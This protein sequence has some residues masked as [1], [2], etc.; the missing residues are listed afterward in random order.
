MARAATAVEQRLDVA[1]IFVAEHIE[2]DRLGGQTGF[3]LTMVE[4]QLKSLGFDDEEIQ[5]GGLRITSTFDHAMQKAATAAVK[6]QGPT[7][8]TDGLRIGLLDNTKSPV[9]KML[10]RLEECLAGRIPGVQTRHFAKREMGIPAPEAL[11]EALGQVDVVVNALGGALSLR[12][13]P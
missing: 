4:Q 9:D 8:G 11:L 13:I 1:S 2:A 12:I 3:L 5:R 6:A 7:S 10:R